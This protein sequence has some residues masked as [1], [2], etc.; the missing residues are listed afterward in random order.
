MNKGG[1]MITVYHAKDMFESPASGFEEV[2]VVNVDNLNDAFRLT[3]N[4]EGSWSMG[5]E[6]EVD[7]EMVVNEDYDERVEVKKELHINYHGDGKT[8]GLRST[9]SGDVFFDGISHYFLV[10]F[11]FGGAKKIDNFSLEGFEYKEERI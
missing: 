8:L 10:P 2:A 7:G 3:N 1:K 9:S 5:S 6:I 4:I 11:S